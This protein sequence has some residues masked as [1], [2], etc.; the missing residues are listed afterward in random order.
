M[1]SGHLVAAAAYAGLVAG[2]AFIVLA[3]RRDAK[4]TLRATRS[5]FIA[6][7]VA[8]SLA[9][10]ALQANL[11]PL[12][13]W[14]LMTGAPLRRY[15]ENP[16]YL[17]IV[18]VDAEGAERAIDY[19]AVEPFAIEELMAW[20][21][22]SFFTLPPAAQDSAA[23]YLLTRV[24]V[25]RERV[26]EGKSPGTQGRLLG[27]LRAPFHLLHPKRWTS[28]ATVPGTAFVGLRVYREAWD[29]EERAAG[30]S[31]VERTLAYSFSPP[32]RP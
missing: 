13:S 24:N 5:V 4:A 30:R 32:A 28:P 20:M 14:S 31:R 15:G 27:P 9:A 12:S 7:I 2:A 17:R 18:A 21:R 16:P 8:V 25:A 3:E 10:G 29:L 23:A 1:I 22:S 19:R 26:R 6:Y 11:W